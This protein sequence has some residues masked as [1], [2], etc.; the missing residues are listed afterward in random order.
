VEDQHI[1]ASRQRITMLLPIRLGTKRKMFSFVCSSSTRTGSLGVPLL[2]LV[3]LLSAAI[4]AGSVSRE[5]EYNVQAKSGA[6]SIGRNAVTRAGRCSGVAESVAV[7]SLC[8]MIR[9][10]AEIR[11]GVVC[12]GGLFC[13]WVAIGMAV[14][15]SD[16]DS[17]RK[18]KPDEVFTQGGKEQSSEEQLADDAADCCPL[19][20]LDNSWEMMR[21]LLGDTGRRSLD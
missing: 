5:C 4:L 1:V 18:W 13:W 12:C 15:E 8:L 20:A 9:V 17:A 6:T 2:W 3:T 19:V 11:C 14:R 16:L 10:E 21:T 7:I